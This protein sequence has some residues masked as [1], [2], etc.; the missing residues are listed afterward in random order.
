MT[1]LD[2]VTIYNKL[3]MTLYHSCVHKNYSIHS[4][5]VRYSQ[6]QN[7]RRLLV[8]DSEDGTIGN[9]CPG[10]QPGI[11][12]SSLR[13]C[14][15]APRPCL[16]SAAEFRPGENVGLVFYLIKPKSSLPSTSNLSVVR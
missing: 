2:I 10:R 9:I 15:R 6:L 12:C 11:C 14:S 16:S 5:L 8:L 4:L 7:P 3:G 13:S 1:A